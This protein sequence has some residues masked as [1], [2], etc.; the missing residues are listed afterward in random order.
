MLLS[1][2]DMPGII[3]HSPQSRKHCRQSVLPLRSVR[4]WEEDRLA[5][6]YINKKIANKLFEKIEEGNEI[7]FHK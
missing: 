2:H 5:N 7:R 3:Q 6:K 1:A 4:S